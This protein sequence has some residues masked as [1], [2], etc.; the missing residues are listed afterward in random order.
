[1]SSRKVSFVEGEF[2]HVYNRGNSKQ[3]IFKD[4]QDYDRF[5]GL[6]FACNSIENLKLGNFSKNKNLFDLPQTK[7]LVHI[8]SYCLMPN[9]LHILLT[10][11]GEGNTSL[12]MKKITTAYVMY[13]NQ[14]YKRSGGLFEGKF[15]AEHVAS[16]RYL[17]YLFSYI[18]LNPLKLIEPKWKNVGI[19]NRTK[20][21]KYLDKYQYSSYLDFMHVQRKQSVILD[22]IFFPAYFN[23]KIVFKKEIWEW[24]NFK[25]TT[26]EERP[27]WLE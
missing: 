1:M 7:K 22:V 10:D 26:S 15:K 18:H 9:H 20:V 13:F 17:K 11:T 25:T 2:Y 3:I 5:H 14:K 23:E 21:L 4:K 19:K 24:I 27:R 16:D 12:F 6:L 8:G